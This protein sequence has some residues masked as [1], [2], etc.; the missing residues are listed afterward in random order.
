MLVL[1]RWRGSGGLPQALLRAERWIHVVRREVVRLDAFDVDAFVD[2][3]GADAR[4]EAGADG[5]R[6]GQ[7]RL[8]TRI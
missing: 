6:H 8:T 2:D 4:S 3:V 5:V 1:L 7:V